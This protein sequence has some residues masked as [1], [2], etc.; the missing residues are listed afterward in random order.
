MLETILNK[1]ESRHVKYEVINLGWWGACAPVEYYNLVTYRY[2]NPDLV[3]VYD[4][5][6]DLLYANARPLHYIRTSAKAFDWIERRMS[7]IRFETW[8]YRTS[9]V[10]NKLDRFI[11]KEREKVI[12]FVLDHRMFESGTRKKLESW[13]G[14]EAWYSFN[15]QLGRVQDSLERLSTQD[16]RRAIRETANGA[17]DDSLILGSTNAE[18]MHVND[19]MKIL[20]G[21]GMTANSIWSLLRWRAIRCWSD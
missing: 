4:G 2:L 14:V 6:N 19:F 12:H 21:S 7:W 10:I 3:I 5:Y 8:L 13:T 18:S 20:A 16:V 9:A 17:D 1:R 11:K 15:A